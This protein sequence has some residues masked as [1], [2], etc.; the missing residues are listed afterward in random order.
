MNTS[1]GIS[2]TTNHAPLV[3]L[4]TAKMIITMPVQT[5]PNALIAI[6]SRQCGSY[7]SMAFAALDDL[8]GLESADPA[9]VDDHAG[10]RDGEAQ[11]HADRIQRDQGR[12][13]GVT[14]DDQ[15]RR[16]GRQP[17]DAP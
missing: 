4:V 7:S 5:A 6:L 12:G 2:T 13:A 1:V 10:L 3:N 14:G 17:H 16:K 15:Q 9:Q 8:A 11:E